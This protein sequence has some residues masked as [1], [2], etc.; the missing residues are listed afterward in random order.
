MKGLSPAVSI[1]FFL[2]IFMRLSLVD[3]SRYFKFFYGNGWAQG[4]P[5]CSGGGTETGV[6]RSGDVEAVEGVLPEPPSLPPAGGRKAPAG[7][8]ARFGEEGGRPRSFDLRIHLVRSA[9]EQGTRA[10]AREF[11]CSRNTVRKGLRRYREEGPKGLE[12][13]SRAPRRIPHKTPPA[14]EAEVLRRRER[15]PGFGAERLKREFGLKPGISAI[16]R[17]IRTHGLSRHRKKKQPPERGS[18]RAEGPPSTPPAPTDGREIPQR[19][20]PVRSLLLDFR[21]KIR[22]YPPSRNPGRTHGCKGWDPPL[23]LL[24]EAEPRRDPRVRLLQPIPLEALPAK[25]T[26]ATVGHHVPVRTAFSG[27]PGIG[28]PPSPGGPL[29]GREGSGTPPLTAPP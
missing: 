7:G 8:R 23:E 17:I 4:A 5:P 16:K 24:R 28:A 9:L 6:F 27:P 19:S 26:S 10:T 3:L 15:T 20:P 2:S 14:W 25:Q 12:D 22:T 11:R 18:P 13:R 29:H 1:L 21:E